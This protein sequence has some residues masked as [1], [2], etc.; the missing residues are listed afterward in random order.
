MAT[1]ITIKRYN[2]AADSWQDLYPMTTWGN[3]QNKPETYAPSSHTHDYLPLSGGTMTGAISLKENDN[4]LEFRPN[5]GE[6]KTSVVYET[7]GNEALVFKTRQAVTSFIFSN[8]VTSSSGSN[9]W[10]SLTPGLQIKNN[11]V[12][13]GS[14]IANSVTP[15]YKLAV[16]GVTN[17]TSYTVNQKATMQYN[18]TE[19]CIEFVFA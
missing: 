6:Y 4:S 7:N 17:S 10:Q 15:T 14:L 18:S 16:N 12:S 2:Q 13:I 3:I 1:N 11:C 19:D 9:E 8:G 5:N